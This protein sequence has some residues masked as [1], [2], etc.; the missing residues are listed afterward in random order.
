M[1]DQSLDVQKVMEEIRREVIESRNMTIR[2]DNALKTLHA[3]LKQVSTNQEQFQKKT[4]F[5][6]GTSY[7]I[8]SVLC[9]VGASLVSHS[10]ASAAGTEKVRLEQQVSDLTAS[11]SKLNE[12]LVSQA[13]AEQ[14]ASQTYKMIASSN[15][16]ERLKGLDAYSKIDAAKLS[17]FEKQVL[18][19]RVILV[20][21]ELGA[22]VFEKGKLA[23][24]R[25]EWAEAIS[26]L[27]RFLAMDPPNDD[28][29]EASFFLGNSYFQSRKFDDAIKH[30]AF[31]VDGDKRSK[32]RDFAMLMLMQSY[33]M[34]GR[35]DDAV[36]TAKEASSLYATSDFRG[37]FMARL[38]KPV[39]AAVEPA[40]VAR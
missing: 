15:G 38:Q 6:S 18:E 39:A 4:W 1:A 33:D 7:L 10:Q 2:T 34:V 35:R 28:T 19:D 26:Q 24:R 21:K 25:Q 17:G 3:E 20:R 12:E 5:A 40:P 16:D 9:A 27:T 14:L 31:F 32:I 13:T 29:L 37:Q 22:G 36:A 11:V 30:L 8:F 23:F